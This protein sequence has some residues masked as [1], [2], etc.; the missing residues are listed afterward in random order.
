MEFKKFWNIIKKHKFGI[1]LIPLLVMG[2]TFM[3]VRKQP[4]VYIS[5]SRLSAGL[6]AGSQDLMSKE[7][8]MDS[9]IT[10]TFTNLIQTMQLKSMYDQVSYIL[11]LHDLDPKNEPFRKPSKLLNDLNPEARKHA[12]EVYTAKH[13]NREALS[14]YDNDQK[15]LY[16][17]LKSMGYNYE[18][19]R[20]KMKIYR[21]ENSDF[22]DVE[23]ES[24]NPVLSAFVV[25]TLARE[26]ITYYTA[27]ADQNGKRN[28]DFLNAM[29][30]EKKDSLDRKMNGLKDYKINQHVLNLNEQAKSLFLQISDFETRLELAQKEIATDSGAIK[31]IDAKLDPDDKQKMELINKEIVSTQEKLSQLNN[32]YIKSNFD[33][34]IK[35]EIDATKDILNQRINMATDKLIQS[36]NS[37]KESMIAQ[38]LKLQFELELARNS[39]GSYKS[40]I[41]E[42]N[43]KLDKL[44]PREAVI[45]A[46]EGDIAVASQEYLE[47][48]KKYNQ[49]SMDLNAAAHIKQIEMAIP[50]MKMPSKKSI[51]VLLSGI[52]SF[53]FYLLVLFVLF[54]L[55]DS[56][57]VPDDLVLKT[58]EKVLGFLPVIKSSFLD[59]QKMWS[60]DPINPVNAE[61]KKLVRSTRQDLAKIKG[62]K[63]L[64][65]SNIE[66]KNLIRSTRFEINMALMGSRNLVVTST[67][68][69]EG[70]TLFSLSLVSAYQMTNKKVLLIDGNFLSPDIT[71]ITQPKYYIEDYLKGRVSLSM[72]AESGNVSVLGNQGYD[73]SLFEINSEYQI[74]QKLLELK[75][76]F[77]LIIIEASA[78]NTLNQS[79]EWISVADRVLSVFEANTSI[80]HDMDGQIEYLKTL[81]SKFIGFVMN[82]VT[83]NDKADFNNTKAN[84]KKRSSKLLFFRREQ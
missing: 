60:I 70:K 56:V 20:D 80:S 48:L 72:I 65:S 25:N 42:L 21:I 57:K 68:Q 29:V 50:G 18:A 14:L 2:I 81:D 32:K 15:G 73:V 34:Y 55:D 54:Y 16:E 38:K 37:N 82:K 10:Q 35:A 12:I 66:F 49:A 19:L 33:K 36:P 7:V 62:S 4:S 45:Q 76:V 11:M 61:I 9:K 5:K 23:F 69:A 8:M 43:V 44:V 13:D 41:E 28:V 24:D 77:D 67:T 53:V 47:I 64:S 39:I 58:D 17:V 79:K 26:F 51:L 1:V 75:D 52:V 83:D 30:G 46:Y 59:I 6:T 63:K 84:K 31:D 27:Y 78:L 3:L 22:I 74:E 71:E 40:A